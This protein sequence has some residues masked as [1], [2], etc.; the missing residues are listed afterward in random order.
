[1][2]VKYDTQAGRQRAMVVA[3]D[4]V[5]THLSGSASKSREMMQAA[6]VMISLLHAEEDTRTAVAGCLV[7]LIEWHIVNRDG[8]A[9][10]FGPEVAD[11][12]C[13][14]SSKVCGFEDEGEDDLIA[15]VQRCGICA[16]AIRLAIMRFK[17]LSITKEPRTPNNP[18]RDN[19]SSLL[20]HANK[21]Y[22]IGEH[23]LGADHELMSSLKRGIAAATRRFEV[24]RCAEEE[25]K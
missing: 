14:A 23:H 2:K 24:A 1:M 13:A 9:Q 16:I 6:D 12:A 21:W 10:C 4:W 19:R 22:V 15:R 3:M 17:L 8:I 18:M 7:P 25:S 5:V 11:L 20:V